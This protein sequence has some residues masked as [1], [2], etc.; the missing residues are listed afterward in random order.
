MN[1]P[2]EMTAFGMAMAEAMSKPREEL[3]QMG[4][5]GK[6]WMRRDFNWTSIGARM[7]IAYEWLLGRGDK[8]EW[9]V[10]D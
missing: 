3:A 6:D 1:R 5:N 4:G 10:V 9:V 2:V 8:P 7:K